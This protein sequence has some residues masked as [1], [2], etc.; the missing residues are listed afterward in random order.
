MKLDGA[1]SC[2]LDPILQTHVAEGERIL[3]VVIDTRERSVLREVVVRRIPHLRDRIIGIT[4]AAVDLICIVFPEACVC[5]PTELASWIVNTHVNRIAEVFGEVVVDLLQE[6][7]WNV[8]DA[9]IGRDV[10]ANAGL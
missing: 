9:I 8:A 2:H 6:R 1:L 3:V 7:Q 10:G 4:D 5:L